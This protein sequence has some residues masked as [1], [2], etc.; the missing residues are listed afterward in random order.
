MLAA[1]RTLPDTLVTVLFRKE[2]DGSRRID[3]GNMGG[4]DDGLEVRRRRRKEQS[5]EQRGQRESERGRCGYMRRSGGQERLVVRSLIVLLCFCFCTPYSVIAMQNDATAHTK[6]KETASLLGAWP[7][8][9]Q[10]SETVMSSSCWIAGCWAGQSRAAWQRFLLALASLH[11]AGQKATRSTRLA[12][13]NHGE[14]TRGHQRP[15]EAT[16]GHRQRNSGDPRGE[17]SS[18]PGLGWLGIAPEST[19]S[20]R[21]SSV[22]YL[23]RICSVICRICRTLHKKQEQRQDV[24]R[25][26][27]PS[28]RLASKPGS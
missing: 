11:V 22:P 18:S 4:A 23:F 24:P 7:G 19:V 15:P 17:W 6:V 3:A 1:R 25:T 27:A 12:R 28:L 26:T 16:R 20:V 2:G 8:S 14:A 5:R 10:Q 21:R 9:W 13:R